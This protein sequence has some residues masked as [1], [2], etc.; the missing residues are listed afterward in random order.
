MGLGGLISL[1]IFVQFVFLI[2]IFDIYFKSPIVGG[3][4][5]IVSDIPA[6]SQRVVVISVDGLRLDALLE[7]DLSSKRPIAPYIRW[8]MSN[9]A[10]GVS[11]CHLPTE[12]RPGH[13]AMLAGFYEDPSAVT[14]GWKENPVD[15]DSIF[16]RSGCSFS[17]G[18]PDIVGI[19]HKGLKHNC[20]FKWVYNENQDFAGNTMELDNWVLREVEDFFTASGNPLTYSQPKSLFFLHL[21]GQDTSGH[22]HKPKTD[23]YRRNLQ[24]VDRIV[25]DVNNLFNRVF[26][27]N[28]TAFILTADHGMTDWGSH[29]AGD[30][31][32]TLTPIV[33]W[34]S[35]IKKLQDKLEINQADITPLIATLLGVSVPV[36]SIGI[37]P[38]G[39]LNMS[40][41]R[42]AQAMLLNAL[43]LSSQYLAKR[44]QLEQ[45]ST[46][47]KIFQL[48]RTI[49]EKFN[50]TILNDIR[51]GKFA[52]ANNRSRELIR[53]SLD[54]IQFYQNYYQNFLYIVIVY[55]Y[56]AWIIFLI[57][58]LFAPKSFDQTGWQQSLNFLQFGGGRLVLIV[59]LVASFLVYFE[60][61]PLSFHAYVQV[62]IILTWL[63]LPSFGKISALGDFLN[64]ERVLTGV[65]VLTAVEFF[66]FS[67]YF[68]WVL[69]L[70]FLCIILWPVPVKSI[71]SFYK[72]S[73]FCFGLVLGGFSFL[74]VVGKQPQPILILLG[75]A[76]LSL[77][78]FLY[79]KRNFLQMFLI[80][81]S[82]TNSFY[83][84]RAFESDSQLPQVCQI[85]SW[86]LLLIT[87][88]L[89]IKTPQNLLTKLEHIFSV[90]AV[91]FL[92]LTISHEG[93]FLLVLFIHLIIWVKIE[94][95]QSDV[96][97]N[98]DYS[99]RR[100]K[101][102][103]NVL[104][105]SDLR[106]AYIF[107]AYIYIAFFG[108]GNL[109]TLNS[110]DPAWVRCFLTTFS[111]FTM[112]ALIL[113][114]VLIPF[115]AVTLAFTVLT[116]WL[117]IRPFKIFTTVLVFSNIM[118][119]NF[120]FLVKN[121]GSWLEIGTSLSHY[122]IQ[123]VSIVFLLV[124]YFASQF[125]IGRKESG[126][127]HDC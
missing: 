79:S 77:Y 45:K 26:R 74:P 73:Y 33:A 95:I 23:S 109:A 40:Q 100:H 9:H 76:S 105:F 19:F 50:E 89:A 72:I 106:R 59:C 8:I 118:A 85:I 111:P 80:L 117:D 113:L 51:L 81:L 75:S 3:V 2:A 104:T 46:V 42:I 101:L 91:P 1:A 61:L 83:V 82:G 88:Y 11:H 52:Q 121:Q 48:S 38:T 90:L 24:N 41:S 64:L 5:P 56:L 47:F 107:L 71:P 108:L 54:G 34:G 99:Y 68:R 112:T 44:D 110:F 10:W 14:K 12:S 115:F 21:L 49:V 29:G 7:D 57:L 16:N 87:P 6:P 63:I 120:L 126:G 97:L 67:F 94:L 25:K 93:F 30:P 127:L 102:H 122:I 96:L 125:V 36:N 17:W 31:S 62:A 78:F 32:E 66:V 53:L 58:N 84:H 60:N 124:L 27:D 55:S 18:S 4:M 39:F 35:G 98:T 103:D 13:V 69:S 20:S 92:L 116:V 37:L 15:F 22:T 65:G 119:L 114:K 123:Q 43:Q 70:S 86:A 28:A